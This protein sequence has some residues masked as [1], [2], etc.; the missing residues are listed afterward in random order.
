MP[1]RMTMSCSISQLI[2]ASSNSPAY[3]SV[4]FASI[5]ISALHGAHHSAQKSTSTGLWKE[6]SITSCSKLA[7]PEMSKM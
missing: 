1:K 6:F 3:S 2:L 5:G 7:A 4:I